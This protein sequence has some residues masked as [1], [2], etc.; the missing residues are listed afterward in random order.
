MFITIEPGVY[1]EG[2]HGVRTENAVVVVKDI[3]TEYGQFYSFDT[4][5]L[6]PIDTSCLDLELMTDDELQWLNDYH[7]KVY[8]QVA[9]L[10]SERAKT[11]WSRKHS[12]SP[13]KFFHQKGSPV[14]TLLL[15]FMPV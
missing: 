11:G 12:L 10:V 3:Q 6:V 7:Q 15:L 5:T 13:D 4:F 8:Q 9:P 14:G 2:S 1:T